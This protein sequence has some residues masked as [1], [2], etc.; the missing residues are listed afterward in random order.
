MSCDMEQVEDPEELAK[1]YLTGLSL[2]RGDSNNLVRGL[3]ERITVLRG[4]SDTVAGEQTVKELRQEHA[5]KFQEILP[6]CH[7][8]VEAT[9]EKN[10]YV[11]V[12][13][14]IFTVKEAT[15]FIKKIGQ[16][17]EEVQK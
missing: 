9:P 8:V 12:V 15:A 1:R 17:I 7:V 4:M 2:K 10:I 13:S 3:L 6:L 11:G 16:A 14:K 5:K